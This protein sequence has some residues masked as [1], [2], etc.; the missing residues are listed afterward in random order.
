LLAHDAPSAVPR[1]GEWRNP[2]LSSTA[3]EVAQSCYGRSACA[4]VVAWRVVADATLLAAPPA[5][6]TPALAF[7]VTAGAAGASLTAVG[8]AAPDGAAVTIYGR[9]DGAAFGGVGGALPAL[10]SGW[11]QLWSGAWNASAPAALTLPLALPARRAGALLVVAA[12]GARLACAHALGAPDAQLLADGVRLTVG[13]GGTLG[14]AYAAGGTPDGAC[15]WS[16]LM[17]TYT[18]PAACAP[19]PPPPMPDVATAT[20]NALVNTLDD[21]LRA[22]ANP[23]VESVQLAVHL[24]LNGTQLHAALRPDGTRTLVIEG[25]NSCARRT[26]GMPLCSISARGASRI[27]S[28]TSGVALSLGHLLLRD[29]LAPAGGFGGCVLADCGTDDC[30][31]TL[32]SVRFHNCKAPDGAGGALAVVGGAALAAVKS[33]WDGNSAATGGALL[34]QGGALALSACSFDANTAAGRVATMS[35]A[36]LALSDLP[37]AAGGGVALVEASGT[38]DGCTFA[39][40]AALTEDVVLLSNPD[41]EQARGGALFLFDAAVNVSASVFANNT[42]YFGGGVYVDESAATMAACAFVGNLAT[43]GDGGALFVADCLDLFFL[44]DTLVSGNVAGGHAGGGL[45]VFNSSVSISRS[46]ITRNAA[47]DGCGGGVGLDAGAELLLRDGTVVSGNT[48]RS[49]GG[50]CCNQCDEM[51]TADAF[52]YDNAATSGSGG[53]VFTSLTPTTIRNT[54]LSGNSAPSGGAVAAVSAALN[55]SDC[56]LHD[57]VATRTHGGAVLHDASDD[58]LQ[59]VTLSR[60]VLANNT[61]QGAGGAVALLWSVNALV[62]SCEFTNNSITSSAPSGGALCGLHVAALVISN[63]TFSDNWVEQVSELPAG[64]ALGYSNSVVAPGAG[65]GGALWLG[66]DTDTM[67]AAVLNSTLLRNYAGWGGGIYVTGVL[68]F[69]MR[70]STLTHDHAIGDSSEGGGLMTDMASVADVHDT[71]FYSCAAVR[72]G[73]G[74]HG[75]A[76]VTSYADCM[77]EENVGKVGDDIKGSALYLGEETSAVSVTRSTFLNNVGE[78]AC[79][80]TVAMSR[81]GDTRLNVTDSVFDGNYARLGGAFLL[82]VLSQPTQFSLSGVTFRNNRAYIG[83]VL[84]SESDDFAGLVCTPAPCDA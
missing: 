60:C 6:D 75:A 61:C 25:T 32:D 42:A 29:G 74:W 63:C 39:G 71:R 23:A 2:S 46:V 33:K 50:L 7:S 45:G 49:G 62:D 40:N 35:A 52:L 73:A 20:P 1:A 43:L 36:T 79:E 26:P 83:G 81:S 11:T 80:G 41:F 68:R 16:G 72:G 28:V 18:T 8:G 55:M 37:G 9:A 38:V 64:A 59:P 21:L 10:A 12:G 31:L 15:A 51:L 53:A 56:V 84:Y 17:L 76:S 19:P 78:D 58:A 65:A 44:R 54:T 47:A 77:F 24:T 82:A 27:F 22:L 69:T 67:T 30:S 70:G 34:V 14:A 66:A 48:A 57:N 13:Q 3:V 5:T 4:G